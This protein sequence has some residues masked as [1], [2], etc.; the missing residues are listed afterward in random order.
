MADYYPLLAR[1]LDALPDRSP[2]LRRAVYDRARSALIAQLRSLDP[3]V[4]EADIDLERQALDTAI[5]R[6]EAEY[7]AP[8]AAASAP[9]PVPEPA[10]APPPPPEAPRPEPLAPAPL[11][12][13][14]LPPALPEPE[15]PQNP[16]GPLVLPPASMPAG[17]GADLP[18]AEPKPPG[19][20]VPFMPPPRRVKAEEAPRPA[21]ETAD[22]F[23][24]APSSGD[25]AADAPGADP[26]AEPPPEANGAG[27][28]GNGRQRPRI[29]VVT[30][31]AGRSRLL[32]N[33]FVGGVLAAVIAL[34]AVAA[35][36]LRDQLSDLQ[37]STAEQESPAEKPDAKFSDRV[38]A[39]H[40]EAEARP[41]PA[42]PG[43]APAQPEVTV[44]QRAIL[45]EENQSDTRAQ[46]IATNGNAVWRTEAVNGG[47]GEPLQTVLRVNVE[48]P[49]A[50]LTLAMTM[51]KNLDANLPA[52]HTIELAFTNSGE[53]GAKR[54]VQNIGLLQ[55]KDEEAARGSPVSG[56]PVRVRENLFLIGLSSLKGDVDRNTELLLHK[57][58]LDLALT[59]ADGQRA[60][61]SFEKGGAGAQAVQ[62]A[63]T[64]W[65][66]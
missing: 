59:Y 51:R 18:P 29:D 60:V 2:A 31:P 9:Q 34:I 15:P 44:S 50:G 19:E 63:F 20:T 66:E 55:L 42:A 36:F 40:S 7:E 43:T 28:A 14:F 26:T 58:W 3:P 25:A 17:I 45:Y 35:F 33:L 6:L 47:Q 8:P 41:K 22:G 56:L 30:P 53:A 64:Q 27:E 11:P 21:P 32:R 4:P 61:I 54:A 48:F 38:G 13:E 52:S 1:A 65:R 12:A 37:Q 23:I 16:D 24:P 46:P 62:S 57:N 10:P 39:E 5:G 49:S